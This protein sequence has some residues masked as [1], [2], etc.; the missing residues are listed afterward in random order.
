MTFRLLAP[1]AVLAL[2][3]CGAVLAQDVPVGPPP[4][5]VLIAP[6][7]NG[8]TITLNR[9]TAM[10]LSR[11]LDNADEKQISQRI[12]DEAAKQKDADPDS[13]AKLELIAFVVKSQ[14]PA[15][16]KQLAENMGPNGVVIRVTGLQK[17]EAQFKRPAMQKAAAVVRQVQPLLPP[18]AQLTVDALRAMA[19]TTPLA[20]KV[21]PIP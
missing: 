16:K 8:Y 10:L 4:P 3:P 15:F 18:D 13:A 19:R 6:I 12:R 21:E 20:W 5:P 14:L 1:A 9:P 17:P 2:A 7:P 11:A